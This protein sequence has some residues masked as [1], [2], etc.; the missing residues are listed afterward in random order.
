MKKRRTIF[1]INFREGELYLFHANNPLCP[2]SCSLWGIFDKR[3]NRNIYLE[4]ST[5]D[6]RQYSI[7]H[8][9]PKY[10][11]YCRCAT[12]AEL[13]DYMYNMGF[14]DAKSLQKK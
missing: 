11:H 13:K 3:T 12:R 8:I 7:W 2:S 14:G 5:G 6:L 10:Y 1:N 9:L 4:S